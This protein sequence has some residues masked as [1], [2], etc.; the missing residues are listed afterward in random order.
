MASRSSFGAI[1]GEAHTGDVVSSSP[2]RVLMEILIHAIISLIGILVSISMY[3]AAQRRL[4]VPIQQHGIFMQLTLR[5]SAKFAGVQICGLLND[6]RI[7]CGMLCLADNNQRLGNVTLM[8]A[9]TVGIIIA[10]M[11]HIMLEDW[12][13]R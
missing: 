9:E 1:L 8:Y 13:A 10:N 5:H 7:L 6:I 3:R 12:L 11:L 4:R 2:G